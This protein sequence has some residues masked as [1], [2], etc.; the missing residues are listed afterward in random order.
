MRTLIAVENNDTLAAVQ[1]FLRRILEAGIVD[2]LLVPMETPHGAVV[3]ALVSDPELLKNAN[4]LA[5]VMGVNAAHLAGQ[6][7]VREPR[8]RV[9]VVLRSCELRALIELVKLQQASLDDIVTIGV[10]CL[11]TYDVATYAAMKGED[12]GRTLRERTRAAAWT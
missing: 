10:D 11:G 1:G 8:D 9:G 2:S 7:S 3:P 5:P 12:G 4:P 6:V